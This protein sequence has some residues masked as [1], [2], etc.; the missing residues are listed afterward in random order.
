M[1]KTALT[2]ESD[3]DGEDDIASHIVDAE[4]AE[5]R[6]GVGDDNGVNNSD[7]DRV[8]A[9]AIGSELKMEEMNGES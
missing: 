3:E 7:L 2:D 6:T 1:T 9:V 8:D 4:D 5:D